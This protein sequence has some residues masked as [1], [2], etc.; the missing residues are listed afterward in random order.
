M[1]VMSEDHN[2]DLPSYT[3]FWFENVNRGGLFLL[4]GET[5]LFFVEIEKLVRAIQPKHMV[6]AERNWSVPYS[7]S[8]WS[9]PTA[10][11]A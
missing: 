4:N 8:T 10:Q 1:A 5:F 7:P 6:K 3:R 9:K 11:T 2:P